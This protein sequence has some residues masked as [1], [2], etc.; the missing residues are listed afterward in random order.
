MLYKHPLGF[1][2][3]PNLEWVPQAY[4]VDS[5]NTEKTKA[6]ALLGA[7]VGYDAGG[8]V[9]GLCRGPKPHEQKVHLQR[10]RHQRRER[11]SGRRQP[12]LPLYEPGSGRAVYAGVKYRW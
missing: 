4:Y 11:S 7:K 8:A 6:Y 2:V 3:G 5:A 10:Q 9:L 1:D 12:H